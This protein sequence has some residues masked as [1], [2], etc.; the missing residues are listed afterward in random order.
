MSEQQYFGDEILPD[1]MYGDW[2]SGG[3]SPQ[4]NDQNIEQTPLTGSAH[5]PPPQAYFKGQPLEDFSF[6]APDKIKEG[7]QI[8]RLINKCPTNQ[9]KYPKTS[10]LKAHF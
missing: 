7:Q 10:S 4:H 8:N 2:M 3:N 5:T 6:L 9:G 1:W